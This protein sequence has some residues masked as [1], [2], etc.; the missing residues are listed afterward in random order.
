MKALNESR[1]WRMTEPLRRL[2]ELRRQRRAG[3]A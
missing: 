3:Q 1:S 2:N